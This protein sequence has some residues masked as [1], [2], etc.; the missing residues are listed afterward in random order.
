MSVPNLPREY[1][2]WRDAVHEHGLGYVRLWGR[3]WALADRTGLI[4]TIRP[5]RGRVPYTR[6]SPL[7]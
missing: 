7:S 5:N 6:S 3:D 2:V 1:F 4:S